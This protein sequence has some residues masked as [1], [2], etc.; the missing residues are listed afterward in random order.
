MLLSVHSIRRSKKAEDRNLAR[1]V[2]NFLNDSESAPPYLLQL[3]VEDR[4]GLW[5]EEE[6]G[7]VLSAN[8]MNDDTLIR[9]ATYCKSLWSLVVNGD[10]GERWDYH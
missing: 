6:E 1:A 2:R 7:D 5:E 8:Q 3:S 9:V 10:E 4:S